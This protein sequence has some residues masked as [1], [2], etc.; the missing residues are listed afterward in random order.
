MSCV[1]HA[2]VF[3]AEVLNSHNNYNDYKKR[4]HERK[5]RKEWNKG[6]KGNDKLDPG[7]YAAFNMVAEIFLSTEYF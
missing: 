4:K 2:Q 1:A 7:V 3:L 5:K 6:E